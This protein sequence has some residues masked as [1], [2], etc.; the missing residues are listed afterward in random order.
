VRDD[1][2]FGGSAPP[3]DRT[4]VHPEQRLAGYAGILQADAYA[5]FNA[6]YASD[7]KGGAITEGGCWAH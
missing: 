2:P 1:R 4:A 3:A 6:L 5:G 7:R